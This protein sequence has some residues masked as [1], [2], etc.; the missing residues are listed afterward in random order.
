MAYPEV[1]RGKAL[2]EKSKATGEANGAAAETKR[3]FCLGK[4]TVNTGDVP[5]RDASWDRLPSVK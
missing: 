1:K 2:R 3:W 4:A 5:I